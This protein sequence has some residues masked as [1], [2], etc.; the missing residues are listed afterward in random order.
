MMKKY[1]LIF[2]ALSLFSCDLFDT[3]E[4]EKDPNVKT[5]WAQDLASE[6][7]Y[8]LEANLLAE[9]RYCNVW[10]EKGSGV[11][12]N[13]AREMANAYDND[14]YQ[15]MIDTFSDKN[16]SFLGRP[17]PNIMSLADAL[18]DGDGKLTILLLDIKDTYHKG[19]NDSYVAGYFWVGN[20]FDVQNSNLCDMIYIDTYP[21]KP[22]SEDSNMTLAHEMQHLMNFTTTVAK[23]S[24]VNVDNGRNEITALYLMD[25][26]IDEGLSSAAEWRYAGKHIEDKLSWFN[27]NGTSSMTGLIDRGNNFFVWG[28]YKDPPYP[29]YAILDEYATVYLFFQWLRLQAGSTSIYKEIITSDKDDHRAV[30]NAINKMPNQN[31]SDWEA[32]L[33]TWLAANY[34]NAASGPYGYKGELDI[35]TSTVPS[36]TTSLS[37]YPGE[38]VYSIIPNSFN[39][40]SNGAKIRYASLDKISHAVGTSN[41]EGLTLLTFNSNTINYVEYNENG[42]IK[43]PIQTENG[44]TTGV[45][46]PRGAV[47]SVGR[48]VSAPFTGPYRIDAGDLLR[49]SGSAGNFSVPLE[50]VI[51]D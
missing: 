4:D 45:S 31:Y 33:K 47:M 40:P 48:S 36:G 26:W 1:L 18:T 38:G 22:A 6:K 5:F 29:P 10:V 32:L 9:G 28:N 34:I 44:T 35:K 27:N 37:L 12:A 30:I 2:C 43:T 17:F 8:Q 50:I 25:T 39:L 41:T 3:K 19:V 51:H 24:V 11:N 15:K 23:R 21:G 46:A 20:F 14:I 49:R 7:F 16:F 13:T 42:T